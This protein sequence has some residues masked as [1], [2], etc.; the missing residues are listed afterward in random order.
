MVESRHAR[1]YH[2]HLSVS[3]PV[4]FWQRLY[5]AVL[6]PALFIIISFIVLRSFSV[7]PIETFQ[8]VSFFDLVLALFTTFSRLVIAYVLAL[9][10]SVPLGILIGSSA[11]LERLLLPLVDIVQSIPVL[12]FFPVIVLFFIK[13]DFQSGAAIFIL[14]LS[15]IWNI[16][17][18]VIGGMTVIPSDIKEAAQAFHIR[19]F[20][21][22]R[23]VLLPAVVPHIITGSL[24]AWAQGWN[25]II[26]A[27]VIHAY[28]PA[29][30]PRA[31]LFGIG[32]ILV[33]SAASGRQDIFLASIIIMILAIAFL[34]F[35]VWQKLLKYGEKY[36]FE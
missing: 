3:Y 26:V 13:F 7:L 22:I 28:I 11:K 33:N 23:K 17:F 31:D 15:M 36:R 34:N 21:Y 30:S 27:E 8:N 35:F 29:G 25:I 12:A 24:L 14:F 18:T 19:G 1:H 6:L 20:L 10:F 2:R 9:I 32:S 5:S 4:S 16:V